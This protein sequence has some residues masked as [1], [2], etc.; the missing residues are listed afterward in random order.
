M[1]TIVIWGISESSSV[2]RF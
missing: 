2:R 1:Y